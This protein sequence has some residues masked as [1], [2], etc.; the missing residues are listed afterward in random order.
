MT[1]DV[2]KLTRKLALQ[3]DFEQLLLEKENRN[4]NSL[5]QKYI[6]STLTPQDALIGI[7][8]IAGMRSLLKTIGRQTQEAQ[9]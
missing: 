9:N 3:H 5:I 6:S 2:S 7:G 4:L 1:A 8:V